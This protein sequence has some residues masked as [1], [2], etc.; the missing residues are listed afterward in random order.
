M[1]KIVIQPDKLPG[2]MFNEN[3]CIQYKKWFAG[4][5][6]NNFSQ[7]MSSINDENIQWLSLATIK[8]SFENWV[9]QQIRL[10]SGEEV[11][12]KY[13]LDGIIIYGDTFLQH[14]YLL[15]T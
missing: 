2:K 5:M 3:E 11:H 9:Q 14:H 4:F 6:N 12:Q 1:R 13:F 7:Y 8:S 15:A 10:Q